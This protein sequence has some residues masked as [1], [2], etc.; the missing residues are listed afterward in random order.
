MASAQL[1]SDEFLDDNQ[2]VTAT[3]ICG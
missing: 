2:F 1:G 3:T